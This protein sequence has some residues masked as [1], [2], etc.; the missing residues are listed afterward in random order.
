MG[1]IVGDG[2][3]SRENALHAY[4]RTAENTGTASIP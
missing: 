4:E 2:K 1:G 3:E